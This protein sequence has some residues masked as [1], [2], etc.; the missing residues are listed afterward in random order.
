VSEAV[1]AADARPGEG[2]DPWTAWLDAGATGPALMLRPRQPGDR[3]QPQGMAGHRM[4]LNEFM[5]NAKIPRA[6][7]HHWPLLVGGEGI[8]WVCGLRVDERAAVTPATT[9]VWR[10]RFER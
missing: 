2:A 8:A 6:A 9:R 10:V 3:F 1:D 5:I 7:R 4:K